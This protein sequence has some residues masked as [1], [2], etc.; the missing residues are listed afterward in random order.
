MVG[1]GVGADSAVGAEV[2]PVLLQEE[3]EQGRHL[4][5][6]QISSKIFLNLQN[7]NILFLIT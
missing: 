7:H 1:E 4:G 6:G 2:H 5:A 3:Q